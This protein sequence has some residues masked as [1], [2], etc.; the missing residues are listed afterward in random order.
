VAFFELAHVEI[1]QVVLGSHTR[2]ASGVLTVDPEELA[3]H[4]ATRVRALRDVRVH[5]VRPDES[6]R[7]VCVKDAIEPRA[8]LSG[9]ALGEGSTLALDGLAVLTCGQIVGFQEGIVDMSGPG[10]AHS[11]FSSLQLV[12]IE[13]DVAPDLAA[14]EHEAA[15]R[16]AGLAAAAFL[17]ERARGCAPDR[18]ERFELAAPASDLPRLAYVYMVLTQGLLHDTWFLGRN[19]REGLPERVDP[20]VLLDGGLVSGNCVSACDKNTT[21][22]HQNNPLIRELYARH[23]REL[24]L[25]GVVLT[26]EPTRL[27]EKER[28]A[29]RAVE[30]VKQLDVTGAVISKEGFGNPDA[31]L[32][33][34]IRGLER[35]GIRTVALVDE[36]AGTDGGSQSLADTTDEAD[37]IVS[38]GNAN[39]RIRLPAMERTLGPLARVRDLA[40]AGAQSARSD[41]ALEV[42]LQTLLGSCNQLGT[43]RLRAREV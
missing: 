36:F 41:G 32:M 20:Q 19:A 4:L 12:V 21:W 7:I 30:L 11:P 5:A 18:T 34:L 25:A 43:S 8:K 6:T 27:A 2:I 10:A 28:A 24:D 3:S 39:A 26:P 29:A 31:D 35:E 40:G 13:A 1:R 38:T 14:K 33:L 15:L 22:H 9:G 17:G 42:E 16:A 23:G 37:A